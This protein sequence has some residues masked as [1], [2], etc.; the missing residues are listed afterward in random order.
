M[1]ER[2][3]YAR[4]PADEPANLSVAGQRAGE[5]APAV[6]GRLRDISESGMFI[7]TSMAV[8]KEQELQIEVRLGGNEVRV[9][10]RVVWM[11]RKGDQRGIGVKI[12]PDS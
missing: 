3:R 11:G 9:R 12:T 1:D 4:M 5:P 8:R 6:S 7:E 10:G 2:R